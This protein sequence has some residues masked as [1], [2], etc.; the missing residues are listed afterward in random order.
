MKLISAALLLATGSAI[1]KY[2]SPSN[3]EMMDQL[4]GGTVFSSDHNKRA[5]NQFLTKVFRQ[6]SELGADDTGDVNGKRVITPWTSTYVAKA[7]LKE[8]K[9]IEGEE[10]TSFVE[11]DKFKAM[12]K[13]FD[14][15]NVGT[16]DQRDAYFWAR[17]LVGETY[18][19]VISS[20]G[21]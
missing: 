14:Y 7:I 8:W 11:S 13:E 2:V 21:M 19:G 6:Y 3:G 12:F 9:G 16:I 20:E 10:A 4:L 1:Q 15:Q 18:E 17:K 5:D